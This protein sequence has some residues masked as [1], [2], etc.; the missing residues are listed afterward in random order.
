MNKYEIMKNKKQ[1]E[2]ELS[3]HSGKLFLNFF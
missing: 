1:M 2:K 3:G